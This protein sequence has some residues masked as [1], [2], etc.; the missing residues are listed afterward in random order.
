MIDQRIPRRD[1]I[2][3]LG[4]AAGTAT[5]NSGTAAPQESDRKVRIGIVGGGFGARFHW[6][7]D[8]GCE[9][10]AVSDLLPERRDNLARRYQ[11]STTYDSLEELICDD[12][13]EAVAV[14]TGA[15]DHVRHC[16][17]VMEQGK[18]CICAVPAGLTLEECAAL[19]DAKE[20]QGVKYMMAETS[21][22]RWP[23][24]TA[25]RMFEEGTFGEIKYCE[26]EYYHP[27][28]GTQTD[29][30]SQWRDKEGQMH[31]TWR[32][33]YPP[34]LYPTHSTGFLVGVTGERLVEV[35]CLGTPG[36]DEAFRDNA[37]NNP[38]E[39]QSALFR[40][41]RGNLFRCNV[42]WNVWAHGERAQWFG[43][44]IALLMASWA[45]QPEVI[46]TAEGQTITPQ[47]D[48][49]Q[50]L[51]EKMRY[52][53]GHGG[54]HPF[55]THEFIQA[56]LEDREPAVNVYEAVAMTAPGIVAHESS[57]RGGELLKVPNFDPT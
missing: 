24:I 34:M 19:I 45:G 40:T 48:Y 17:A 50:L 30:L 15:P 28:I 14:F 49:W 23:T 18:H 5:F 26:A 9:V 46:K 53:S 32:W 35:A 55:I 42:M 2:T 29:A 27:Q 54:S 38:F 36:K 21:Y 11:C 43:E 8:P 20:R 4:L 3:A 51:P 25:R 16:I 47:P 39:N 57:L 56:I 37:Y 6:H 41:S 33:G 44:R 12:S 22:Y 7:E 13:I 52:D 1:F 10:V 31:R